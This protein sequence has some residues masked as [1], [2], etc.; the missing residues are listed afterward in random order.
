[1]SNGHHWGRIAGQS[2]LT[3][4]VRLCLIS[5]KALTDWIAM[6][7]EMINMWRRGRGG[8]GVVLC[9]CSCTVDRRSWIPQGRSEES[10]ESKCDGG[11]ERAGIGF[12]LGG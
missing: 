11:L 10:F 9:F 7:G 2:T 4:S 6:A 1:M 3:P 12:L 5:Y 8:E